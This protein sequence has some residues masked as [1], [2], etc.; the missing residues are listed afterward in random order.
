M[1]W[2]GK[3]F[4]GLAV[5]GAVAAIVLSSRTHQVRSSWHR[6]L[7][8]HRG[9]YEGRVDELRKEKF[10]HEAAMIDLANAKRGWGSLSD[11]VVVT[12]V[13]V[14]D[15]YLQTRDQETTGVVA[16][17]A[18]NNQQPVTV[19]GFLKNADGNV[20]FVGTFIQDGAVQNKVRIWKPTW[21]LRPGDDVAAWGSGKWRLRTLIPAHQKTRF[22]NLEVLLTQGDQTADDTGLDAE[23]KAAV[24]LKADTQLRLR[25]SELMGDNDDLAGLKGKLPDYMIDGLVRAIAAAEEERNL[26]IE[27]VD[28]L[29]RDLKL[30]HDR[31]NR[32][33]R[34]NGVLERSLPGSTTAAAAVTR[35]TRNPR[36]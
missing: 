15:G 1:H 26:S 24:D 2:A 28:Q 17:A 23:I 25:F 9:D 27:T 18:A 19:H 5:I 32:L 20:K 29:R 13:N 10:N 4:A 36:K 21:Q 30:N 14:Q 7:A 33:L 22:V 34:Q 11:D 35:V 12:V 6:S 16:T 8:K 3:V 31:A